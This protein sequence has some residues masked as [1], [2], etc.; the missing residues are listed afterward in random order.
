MNEGWPNPASIEDAKE[1]RDG[2]EYG[3]DEYVYGSG[4]M[5]HNEA[6]KFGYNRITFIRP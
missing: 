6:Q 2:L 4:K 3:G 5:Q 1:P